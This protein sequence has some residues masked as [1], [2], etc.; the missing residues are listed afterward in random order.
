MIRDHI[1]NNFSG[2]NYDE[3]RRAIDESVLERDEITLPG[4]GVFLEL[5]WSGADEDLKT[6]MI[7]IIKKKIKKGNSQE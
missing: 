6:K 2:D 5:I 7:E 3:L 4:M 1:I